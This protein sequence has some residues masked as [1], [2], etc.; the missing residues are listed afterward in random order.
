[1]VYQQSRLMKMIGSAV[2]CTSFS[3]AGCDN[4]TQEIEQTIESK[5]QEGIRL[6]VMK[7]VDRI[8]NSNPL[9]NREAYE[10][11]PGKYGV[12]FEDNNTCSIP[13]KNF[14]V[15]AGRAYLVRT[16]SKNQFKTP[17]KLTRD[18]MGRYQLSIGDYEIWIQNKGFY[19]P[20]DKIKSEEKIKQEG[21]S[22]NSY[23]EKGRLII[24][25]Y[26]RPENNNLVPIVPLPAPAAPIPSPPSANPND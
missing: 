10:I 16:D 24:F 19:A 2:I 22:Y 7:E 25:K 26:V 18:Y 5:V 3:I 4:R 17:L 13:F 23:K 9:E 1:M 14:N 21:E 11:E 15:E 20:I 12:F 6:G 8:A